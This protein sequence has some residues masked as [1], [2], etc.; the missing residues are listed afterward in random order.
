LLILMG[1]L[2]ALIG[3]II[4]IISGIKGRAEGEVKAGGVILIGPIPIILGTDKEVV[5]W[6]LIFT[7]SVILLFLALMI[8][9]WWC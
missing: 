3:I 5:K 4:T 9:T 1:F 7:I 2:L 8:I 6:A